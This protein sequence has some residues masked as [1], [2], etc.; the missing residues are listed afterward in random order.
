[1]FLWFARVS[2]L[3]VHACSRL[4][5]DTCIGV[6]ALVSLPKRQAAVLKGMLPLEF[7]VIQAA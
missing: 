1:V 6:D 2:G 4:V 3:P 5:P 7:D